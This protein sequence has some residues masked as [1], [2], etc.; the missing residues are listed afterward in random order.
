MDNSVDLPGYKFYLD[1]ASGERPAVFV[2]YLNV[3]PDES[4]AV[5]GVVFPV[6]AAELAVLDDRE[7]NYTRR[8]VTGAVDVD[9]RAWVYVATEAA[10]ARYEGAAASGVAVV[11]GSY[12]ELVRGAFAGLGDGELRYFD[13]STDPPSVPVRALRR[14]NLPA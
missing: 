12:V 1:P 14:V 13:Q 9:G 5:N 11:D 2:T 8:E 7:R 4:C 6:E 10:R 3:V